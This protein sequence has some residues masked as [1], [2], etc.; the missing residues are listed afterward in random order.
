MNQKKLDSL[1]TLAVD[2]KAGRVFT[3]WQVHDRQLLPLIF[4]P[5][6]LGGFKKSWVFFYAYYDSH[7]SHP[8]SIRDYPIFASVGGLNKKD[9]LKLHKILKH[10]EEKEKEALNKIGVQ[11]EK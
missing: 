8:R 1:K 6:A 3:S 4:M 2:I 11:N 7:V 10:L 9:M 5:I